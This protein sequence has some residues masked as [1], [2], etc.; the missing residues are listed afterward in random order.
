MSTVKRIFL[1][2]IV[3]VTCVGCDQATK[4]IARRELAAAPIQE[5]GNGFFR[6]LY[7]EN[8]GAFLSLG[9]GLH[10]TARFWIFTILVAVLLGGLTWF[11]L[12]HIQRTSTAFI[13][14]IALVTG[15]G[16]GNFI[17]RLLNDGH[18]V[19]FMQIG[20]SPLRTGIFNVADMAIMSGTVLLGLLS[21]RESKATPTPPEQPR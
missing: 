12:Y 19:D 3:L 7:A 20:F 16:L 14:A 18:V 17:D 8:P 1:L 11:A 9:A 4:L 10:P 6:L 21:W 2:L 13:V 5:Y 15:G